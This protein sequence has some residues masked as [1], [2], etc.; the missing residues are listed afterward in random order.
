M[1]IL[2]LFPIL[3]LLSLSLGAQHW[4][5][6]R[7]ANQTGIIEGIEIPTEWDLESNVKWKIPSPGVGWSSPIV[8]GDQVFITSSLLSKSEMERRN[9]GGGQYRTPEGN[10]VT[11]EIVCLDKNT[12]AEVWRK[13]AYSGPTKI[14]THGGSPYSAETP[15]T[16]GE[17]VYVHFGTMGLY[18]FTMEG[19]LVWK[20]DLGVYEMDSEWGT[21]TSPMV[22]EG[23]LF[24]QIDNEDFSALL[25]LEGKTGNELWRVNRE[26]ASNRST[27][28]SG[29]I[30]CGL[31]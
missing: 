30:K 7:G 17:R 22:H 25:A 5:Q 9:A 2:I 21:G 27:P 6:F 26:E 15:A 29:E 24:M 3:F 13:I 14:A 1:K 4:T 23:V 20:K 11:L 19:E 10:E 12:G 28:L 8:W 18:A 16:D 31:N